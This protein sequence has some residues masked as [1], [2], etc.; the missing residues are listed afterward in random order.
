[1][2]TIES[3]TKLD[4]MVQISYTACKMSYSELKTKTKKELIDIYYDKQ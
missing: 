2:T 4:I 1:M 3:M